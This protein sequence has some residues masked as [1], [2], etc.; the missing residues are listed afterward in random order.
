MKV[1]IFFEGY[2]ESVL[3]AADM[4]K[5]QYAHYSKTHGYVINGANDIPD[6]G[7]GVIMDE[8]ENEIYETEVAKSHDWKIIDKDTSDVTCFEKLIMCGIL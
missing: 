3:V 4:T 5:D 7:T 6:Q 8:I 1:L 2:P